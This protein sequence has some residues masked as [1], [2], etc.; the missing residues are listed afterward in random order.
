M[1]NLK[2]GELSSD[3]VNFFEANENVCEG[4]LVVKTESQRT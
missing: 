2:V 3:I 1:P 4:I